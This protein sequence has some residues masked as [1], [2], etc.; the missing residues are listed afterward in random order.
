MNTS[1]RSNVLNQKQASALGLKLAFGSTHWILMKCSFFDIGSE[2]RLNTHTNYCDDTELGSEVVK[3][4]FLIALFFPVPTKRYMLRFRLHFRRQ[5]RKAIGNHYTISTRIIAYD[6][7]WKNRVVEST[8]GLDDKCNCKNQLFQRIVRS[9]SKESRSFVMKWVDLF[10]C[11]AKIIKLTS[12]FN[13]FCNTKRNISTHFINWRIIIGYS[14]GTFSR[15]STFESFKLFTSFIT[16]SLQAFWYSGYTA[17]NNLL[18]TLYFLRSAAPPCS[19]NVFILI[20]YQPSKSAIFN[21][22]ARSSIN[23]RWLE[24]SSQKPTPRYLP[25]L[26]NLEV[27]HLCMSDE[28]ADYGQDTRDKQWSTI[29]LVNRCI[30]RV[31]R[32][33]HFV[34][35][36]YALFDTTR[37]E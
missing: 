23:A 3:E 1:S 7:W 20:L 16:D 22:F 11:V 26:V 17:V 34:L 35:M 36:F 14:W 6:W 5:F 21:F 15:S 18:T 24:I 4:H 29:W 9:C 2:Y 31:T 27:F 37:K 12:Q 13:N 19:S 32:S 10:L 30:R 33:L 8:V 28:M 25:N